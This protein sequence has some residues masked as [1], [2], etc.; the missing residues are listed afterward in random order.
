MRMLAG[1][2]LLGLGVIFGLVGGWS[3]LVLAP[4][5]FVGNPALTP[6]YVWL[7]LCYSPLALAVVL[8]GIGLVVLLRAPKLEKPALAEPEKRA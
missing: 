8:F 3:A 4:W 5:A 7:V 6:D 2:V 1:F